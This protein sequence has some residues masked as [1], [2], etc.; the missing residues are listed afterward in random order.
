MKHFDF[1]ALALIGWMRIARPGSVLGPQQH[2]LTV[3]ESKCKEWRTVKVPLT[4]LKTR[5]ETPTSNP[6]MTPEDKYKAKYGD[7]GQA[8]RLIAAKKKTSNSTSPIRANLNRSPVRIQTIQS[9]LRPDNRTVSRDRGRV[10][11]DAARPEHRPQSIGAYKP[12]GSMH[13]SPLN[14]RRY[15]VVKNSPKTYKKS[16]TLLV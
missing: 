10:I 14:D 12:K 3:M 15:V 7:R 2:F 8:L 4:P 5:P 13:Q 9:P 1:P 11:L 6:E 16:N